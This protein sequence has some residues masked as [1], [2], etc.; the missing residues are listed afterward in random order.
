MM[1]RLTFFCWS[2]IHFCEFNFFLAHYSVVLFLAHSCLP[3]PFFGYSPGYGGYYAPPA[4]SF[5]YGPFPRVG[6]FRAEPQR[7]PT[8]AAGGAAAVAQNPVQPRFAMQQDEV[9][10]FTCFI[11]LKNDLRFVLSP[12]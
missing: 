11:L 3:N 8:A 7:G 5:N 9:E 4:A 10:I 2:F 1:L 12:L 6:P